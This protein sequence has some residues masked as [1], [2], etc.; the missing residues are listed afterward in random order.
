MGGGGKA[1]LTAPLNDGCGFA[2]DSLI[3]VMASKLKAGAGAAD[4]ASKV[5]GGISM[6][7]V[8]VMVDSGRRGGIGDLGGCAGVFASICLLTLF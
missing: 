3:N 1:G 7:E 6:R 4:R 5:N 2:T 8:V